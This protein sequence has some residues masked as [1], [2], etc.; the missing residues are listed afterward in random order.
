[1]SPG[2]IFTW[3]GPKGCSPRKAA[4]RPAAGSTQR[5]EPDWPKCPKVCGEEFAP[6]QWGSFCPRISN[7]SPQSLGFWRP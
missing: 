7:P 2:Q 1:M 6:V 3:S 4:V 5:K